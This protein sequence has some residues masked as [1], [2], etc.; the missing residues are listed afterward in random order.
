MKK[1]LKW[2][3]FQKSDRRKLSKER[4]EGERQFKIRCTNTAGNI[5]LYVL[6][7]AV[8][9]CVMNAERMIEKLCD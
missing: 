4:S 2:G 3:R 9:I 1:I 8:T 7:H 5:L 6:H